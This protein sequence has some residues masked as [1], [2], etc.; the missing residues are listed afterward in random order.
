MTPNVLPCVAQFAKSEDDKVLRIFVQ[1]H[2][3]T[4][5]AAFLA[6]EPEDDITHGGFCS[7]CM[8]FD[9]RLAADG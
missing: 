1:N 6:A 5:A 9:F 8:L 4:S 2:S 3:Q 7:D